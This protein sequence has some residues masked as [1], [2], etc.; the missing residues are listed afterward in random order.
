MVPEI[1]KDVEKPELKRG[2]IHPV[3]KLLAYVE[4]CSC[5]HDIWTSI[6]GIP[7][8]QIPAMCGKFSLPGN[9]CR[10]HDTAGNSLPPSK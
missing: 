2:D 6:A 8:Y 1:Q 5:G 7:E 4:R 9:P 3:F 10:C